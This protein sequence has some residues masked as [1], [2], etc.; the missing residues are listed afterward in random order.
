LPKGAPP[1]QCTVRLCPSGHWYISFLCDVEQLPLS[2]TDKKVGLDMGITSL[3]TTSDGQKYQNPK[4]T[5]K[6]HTRLA[7]AQKH[8]AR[9]INGSAKYARQKQRVAKLYQ[10]IRDT[11]TDYLQKL[12]TKLVRENQT[13][14][15]EDL[16]IKNMC[17]NRRLAGAIS[18]ASWGN[19]KRMLEYKCTWYGRELVKVDRWF[20]S[21]KTCSCC[22]HVCEKLPL[23]IRAWNCVVCGTLHDRDINAAINILSAGTVDYTRGGSVRPKEPKVLDART[24]ETGTRP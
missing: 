10:R 20:P 6:Y 5:K 22:G 8:L 18:D 21:S 19:L 17:G 1:S 3:I 4:T 15:I 7:R 9:K 11:R 2:R 24:V 23:N 13:I 16:A 14:V 12:S